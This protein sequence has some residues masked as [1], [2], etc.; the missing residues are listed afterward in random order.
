MNDNK[1]NG[2]SLPLKIERIIVVVAQKWGKDYPSSTVGLIGRDAIEI[3]QQ[4]GIDWENY[5]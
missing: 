2:N 4:Y 5:R 1:E 3:C